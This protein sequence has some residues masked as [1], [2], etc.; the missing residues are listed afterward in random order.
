MRLT[1]LGFLRDQLK[2]VPP[3]VRVDLSGRTVVVIGANTGLGY[4]AVKHFASMKPSRLI[5]GCRSV[6]RGEDAVAS[7]F[8]LPLLEFLPSQPHI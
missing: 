6:K 4:D 8:R 5:M 2:R 7:M 3:V 1:M